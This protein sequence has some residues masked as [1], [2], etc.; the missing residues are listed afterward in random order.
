MVKIE[1]LDIKDGIDADFAN[2][3]TTDKLNVYGVYVIYD[4]ENLEVIYI[5]SAYARTIKVRLTQYLNA[6]DTGNTLA[7]SIAKRKYKCKVSK[8]TKDQLKDAVKQI[9]TYKIKAIKHEDLEYKLINNAK[10]KYN[11]N[12][13]GED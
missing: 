11:N 7:K 5:G 1:D 9:E 8:L 12:G 4:P 3:K 13:K 2:L 6:T 10:P